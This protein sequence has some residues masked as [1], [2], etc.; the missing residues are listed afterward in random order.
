MTVGNDDGLG[1]G[2]LTADNST[3]NFNTLFPYVSQAS[4][5]NSTLNFLADSAAPEIDYLSMTGSTLNFGTNQNAYFYEFQGDQPNS[6][7]VI[8]LG[9]GTV[10]TFELGT[11]P[12]YYGT[13][14][15]AG[16]IAV[17]GDNTEFV[18]AGANTFTGGLTIGGSIIV[19][20]A[21]NSALG[22]STSPVTLNYG[23]TLALR[24]GITIANPIAIPEDGG[25]IVGYGTI[26]PAAA[27]TISIATYSTLA[28]GAGTVVATFGSPS[29]PPVIGT[30]SF[31]ANAALDFGPN[32]VL[33]FSMMNA[34]GTPG[35][36]YSLIQAAGNLNISANV[37]NPFTIQVVGVASD[38][39]T[40][41]TA[42][43]FD[44]S[45]YYTWT[46]LSAGSITNFNAS[47]F[48]VDSTSQFSNPTGI[49]A[50]SVFQ[51]G[52]DLMLEFNPVPEPSTWLLLAGGLGIVGFGV[53][54]RRRCRP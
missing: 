29:P 52:G 42:N 54:R 40:L 39:Q 4:L 21:N 1:S 9:S 18:L 38:G 53:V 43:T 41:G 15:G 5:S 32:G 50:F 26:A 20:A 35:V 37:D 23:A 2:A 28:G 6:G 51:S 49:G 10:L 46:L 34:A 24:S 19:T 33:Q 16:G 27:Q 25:T 45:Q 14:N 3:L 12:V 7:N 47:A 17:Q 31:G 48:V 11:D 30:L 36:D 13:I 8:N 22:A 44:N